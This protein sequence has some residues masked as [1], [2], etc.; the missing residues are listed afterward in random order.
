MRVTVF[1]AGAIG[2]YLAAKLAIAGS[3]DLS[4][5][6]RGAHLEAIKA[7]GLRLVE[8]GNETVARVR[9][10]ARSEDLGVQDYVV[11]ALKA[12]SLAPALGEIAPLLGEGTAVVTMQNGVPWWYFHKAGGALEGTRLNAV[13]PGGVIWQRI[14]P[15][16]VIGSVV[17]PAVEVDAPGLIRHIEGTRFSLG[18]P[19]GEKSERATALAREM[20]KAGLQAPVREDVRSEIWV[21]LW[22]NL[23]FNPISALT[24]A[25]LAVIV[26][27][28]GTRAVARAMMLEA[29]AIGESLGVRFLIPVDRRIKGAGGVGEHK[30]SM[31]QDL[32]RGRPMEIDAL[33]TAVQELGRL[34]GQPTPTID[35]VLALVR[36]LAIERGCY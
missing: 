14:R 29:Q 32:E 3:V 7:D 17:Y 4:I 2:G 6:A 34:T 22:G 24:G 19:S 12:H 36:R 1:G 5:V 11:L 30:T 9:A 33:V 28:E 18:E 23:S 25:T 8:D 26:A 21:K 20:V 16:R 27:D 10:A 13:D 15:E 31:L 35:G